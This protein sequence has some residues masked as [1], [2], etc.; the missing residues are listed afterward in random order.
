MDLVLGAEVI[1]LQIKC[2]LRYEF[3]EIPNRYRY[4]E[5]AM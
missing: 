2:D 4:C 1:V 3:L 5:S